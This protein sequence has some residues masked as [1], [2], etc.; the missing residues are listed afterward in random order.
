FIKLPKKEFLGTL[1]V[2][3]I[4]LREDEGQRKGKSIAHKSFSKV[5]KLDESFDEVVFIVL[6]SENNIQDSLLVNLAWGPK[7]K[8]ESWPMYIINGYKFHTI[9]WSEGMN[10][11]NHGVYVRGTNGQLE[12]NF[13]GNLSDIIQ[14]EY[15]DFLIM[16]T[17]NI[18]TK[19]HN[20][21][22]IVE[23]RATPRYNKAYDPFIFAQQ[24]EQVY[25]TTYL[26]GHHGWLVVIKTKARSRIIEQ[27]ALYQ[28]DDFVGLQVV[29]HIDSNVINKSLVDI[30]GGGE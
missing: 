8:V 16:N 9:V 10:S 24:G 12:S 25:Y 26:E 28:D 21:Y 19:L 13:Y 2:H 15:I 22:E 7:R 30:D 18:G 4:E 29:L 20:K 23:V 3:E 14:L 5:F 11:I 6:N 17:P 1:K 27:E